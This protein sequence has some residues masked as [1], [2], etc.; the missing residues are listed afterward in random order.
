LPADNRASTGVALVG[1]GWIS[2]A[3]A[4]ALRRIPGLELAAVASRSRELAERFAREE[5]AR[6][7]FTFDELPALLDDADVG[8]V[9]V[10]SPNHLHA[11][12]ALAALAAGKAVVVEKPLCLTL[13]EA[14]ALCAAAARGAVVGYAENLCFAPH[15][16]RARSLLRD[17]AIG[18]VL[19]ARQVEKHAGPY[20]PW[21]FARE[22]AGGGA[23]FDMGCHSLEVL[24]WLLGKPRIVSVEAQLAT[25][26]H[27]ERTALDDDARVVLALEDG[28]RLHSESSWAVQSGMQSTLELHGSEGSLWLDPVGETGLRLWRRGKG[29]E[30][31]SADPL[32]ENGYVA[33]LEHFAACAL[34]GAPPEESAE[35]GRAVLELI[36]AAYASAGERRPIALPFRPTGVERPIDLWRR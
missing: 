3:Y 30:Q 12:H 11:S 24:R 6:N 26:A 36:L 27:G 32:V 31:V 17:G 29:V 21:F 33:Q 25:L 34:S 20:S 4:A 9:C 2:R 28:T 13:D 18:R 1:A 8:L 14:D 5:N 22:E 23:L 19:W 7:A 10:N 16:R 35:D 15:Y